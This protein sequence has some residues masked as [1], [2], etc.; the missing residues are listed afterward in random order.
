M[1][2]RGVVWLAGHVAAK[3]DHPNA[4]AAPVALTLSEGE[5]R[6][7]QTTKL[8]RREEI[9]IGRGVECDVVI[10]DAKASR[11]HCRLVRKGDG[12][13]LEDLGS[14]N[15]T[16]VNGKKIAEQVEMK[17]QQTFKIGDTVF[18]LSP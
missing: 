3:N 12:F 2:N 8:G 4:S 11:K 18:Y 15:G 1:P 9:V 13:V 17:V 16:F 7:T 6:P 5:G 14:K 10:K